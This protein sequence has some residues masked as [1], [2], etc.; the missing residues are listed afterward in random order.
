MLREALFD[1]RL[2]L[3]QFLE[4]VQLFAGH[5]TRSLCVRPVIAVVSLVAVFS[6]ISMAQSYPAILTGSELQRTVPT[7]FYFEGQTGPTQMRNAAGA[8]LAANSN[9]IAALVDTAG[10]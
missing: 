1:A 8:R 2:M 10:Y 6:I 3:H 9:V 7:S 4:T 5:Y